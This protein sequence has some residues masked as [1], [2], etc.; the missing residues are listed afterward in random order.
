MAGASEGPD[1]S[2]D[3]EVRMVRLPEVR[4][5]LRAATRRAV[6][7]IVQALAA[8]ALS[9]DALRGAVVRYGHLARDLALA[10]DEMVAALAPVV[11]RCRRPELPPAE[12]QR[13]V[14]WWAIHG[15]HRVD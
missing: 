7:G 6:D 8:P 11:R 4:S 14:Q 12:L 3:T 5:P 1:S 2:M 10:P 9:L 13:L 15:Y